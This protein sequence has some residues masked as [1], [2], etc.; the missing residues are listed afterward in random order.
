LLGGIMASASSPSPSGAHRLRVLLVEDHPAVR[1]GMAAL[2]EGAGGFSVVGRVDTPPGACRE[3]AELAPDVIVLD[4]MLGSADGLALIK[5]LGSHAPAAR[6]LV[7]TLQPEAV[8]AERCLRAGA[9][10]YVMKSEPVDRLYAAIRTVAAGGLC[11][12]PRVTQAVLEAAGGGK[13]SA[14]SD[15]AR[16]SDRE[17]QVFRLTGLALPTREIAEQLGVS[18]KT[19]EAHRENIKNKLGVHTHAALTARAAAWLREN[20]GG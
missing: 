13:P 6:I 2:L 15:A 10:G 5:D 9:R 1:E 19:V 4:L 16:L 18:V 17:L 20:A 8:Y 7:F 12:S 11:F 14:G 3:A